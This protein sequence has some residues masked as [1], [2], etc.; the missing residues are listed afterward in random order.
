MN[1]TYLVGVLA[2]LALSA[3]ARNVEP[4]IDVHDEAMGAALAAIG[5]E[6]AKRVHYVCE[7]GQSLDVVYTDSAEMSYALLPV[8]GRR[9][10]FVEGVAASGARYT[11][12]KYVWWTKGDHGTLY[13]DGGGDSDAPPVLDGCVAASG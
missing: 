4:Q 1:R 8:A 10:L 6:P 13:D 12:G 5:R 2:G 7:G 9:R 3:C 11:A